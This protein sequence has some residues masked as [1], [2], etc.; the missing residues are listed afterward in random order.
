MGAV[1]ITIIV[2]AVF[3]VVA[4]TAA[5]MIRKAKGKGGCSGCCGCAGCPH[6]SHC[7]GR[8]NK[9]DACNK[10]DQMAKLQMSEQNNKTA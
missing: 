5:A 9:K 7:G 8:Q 3:I 10:S 2:A 1:E 4:V 6:S